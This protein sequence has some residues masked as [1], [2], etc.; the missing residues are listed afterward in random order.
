MLYECAS[1]AQIIFIISVDAF[2]CQHYDIM[3][4]AL[5]I[6]LVPAVAAHKQTRLFWAVAEPN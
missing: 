3:A 2:Y 6:P 5:Q 1:Q 4:Q